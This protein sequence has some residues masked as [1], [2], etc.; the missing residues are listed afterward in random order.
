M[1]YG[2]IRDNI[3]INV[4]VLD[5]EPSEEDKA[6][7]IPGSCDDIV[8]IDNGFWINDQYSNGIWKKVLDNPIQDE[9]I[10]L[11]AQLKAQTDRCDFIEECIAEMAVQV[12]V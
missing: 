1:E 7:L 11:K 4:I 3:C 9:N 5:S 6:I 10:L 8:P 12:Y 2:L